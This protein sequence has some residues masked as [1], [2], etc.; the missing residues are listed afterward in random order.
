MEIND[1]E[2][3]VKD[4][5]QQLRQANDS[6]EKLL[7]QLDERFARLSDQLASKNDDLRRKSL[8]LKQAEADIEKFKTLTSRLLTLIQDRAGDGLADRLRAFD[9]RLTKLMAEAANPAEPAPAA[10]SAAQRVAPSLAG[11]DKSAFPDGDKEWLDQAMK[12]VE[13][14]AGDSP[15]PS[16]TVSP[17]PKSATG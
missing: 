8:Q 17:A 9:D 6:Q 13:Q 1:V 3:R 4:L 5:E 15:K 2:V 16:V 14:L 11:S 10:G 7:R 12:R